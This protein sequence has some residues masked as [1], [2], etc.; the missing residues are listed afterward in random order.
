VLAVALGLVTT[1]STSGPLS[2]TPVRLLPAGLSVRVPRSE[3]AEPFE[4]GGREDQ[5]RPAVL[6]REGESRS[7]E[8]RVPEG[9]QLSFFVALSK[10]FE[11]DVLL[12]VRAN[13]VTLLAARIPGKSWNSWRRLSAPLG[14]SG[15]VDVEFRSERSGGPPRPEA[16]IILGSPRIDPPPALPRRVLVWVSQDALRA[17]HLGAYGYPR[18]TSS[19]FDRLAK[20]GVLFENAVAPASWTL[21]SLASAFTSRYPSYHGAVLERSRRDPESAT[22]FQILGS[23]GFTVIGVSAN[24]FVGAD[25]QMADGFDALWFAPGKAP[26][27]NKTVLSALEESGPGDLALFVHYMDAHF[28]Y[29]PPP[30]YDRKFDP[31]YTGSATGRNF[32]EKRESLTTRDVSHVKALYDGGIA[33]ADDAI[34]ALFAELESRGL[35]GNAI[36]VYS[37]DHGEGFLDHGRFLHAGTL[38]EELVHVPLVLRLP[39]IRPQRLDEPVSLVDLAP[40][41]LDALGIPAPSS[42]QGRSLLPL[43]RGEGFKP[44]PA[45]SEVE[46][47]NNNE[48]QKIS[49]REGHRVYIL[50]VRRGHEIHPEVLKEELF[51]LETDPH[52]QHS[53][54]ISRQEP[55]RSHAVA[56]LADARAHAAP[57]LGARV[58]VDIQERLRAIGYAQ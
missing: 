51:D 28:P 50:R 34:G 40:T 22:L 41:L 20:E 58:P 29:E 26:G 6:L 25:F 48:Y 16:A 46:V 32:F 54:N 37:A 47:T 44:L 23:L 5:T 57:Q 52:E 38:Y 14:M 13:G 12:S 2:S 1:A 27:V 19:T 31:A 18:R 45:F 35:L 9:S 15:T 10:P 7:W 53:L 56:F 55:L 11:G 8:A 42:F 17:D 4:L 30:P 33:C 3:G 43:L 24:R 21:P 36:I 39:G 49:V